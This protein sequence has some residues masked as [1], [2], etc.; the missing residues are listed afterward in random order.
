MVSEI[1]N[2]DMMDVAPLINEI[3]DKIGALPATEEY[4]WCLVSD[5]DGFIMRRSLVKEAI[6]HDD[7]Y[8]CGLAVNVSRK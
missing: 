2:S 3:I 5:Q 4:C 8:K 7:G 6:A 1:F